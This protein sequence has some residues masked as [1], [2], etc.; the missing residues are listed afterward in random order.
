[1]AGRRRGQHGVKGRGGN[2]DTPAVR[3]RLT[4]RSS[5][6]VV[7]LLAGLTTL[8]GA[9]TRPAGAANVLSRT[10]ETPFI[11]GDW[12][13]TIAVPRF[14][15][16]LGVLQGVHL[17]L[18][19]V[20][21]GSVRAENLGAA[22]LSDVPLTAA[23]VAT[24]TLPLELSLL[25]VDG[26]LTPAAT[27]TTS[28]A[29]HD[30][31]VDYAGPSGAT[32]DDL[33]GEDRYSGDFG[34]NAFLIGFYGP[35][36]IELPVTV[37]GASVAEAA[38]VDAAFDTRVSLRASVS[39]DYAL[40]GVVLTV[41]PASASVVA[42]EPVVLTVTVRGTGELG[43]TGLFVTSGAAPD[44]ERQID[45]LAAGAEVTYECRSPATA[46][47]AAGTDAEFG[48]SVWG[49]ADG[50]MV[51]ANGAATVRLTAGVP[52]QALAV[53]VSVNGQ[54]AS[55]PPGPGFAVGTALHL[56]YQVTN[57]GPATVDDVRVTDAPVGAVTCPSG[58]L[59]PGASAAC[60]AD[61]VQTGVAPTHRTV[62][63]TARTPDGQVVS[64]A[65]G[66][67]HFARP[68]A[69]CAA[70]GLLAGVQFAIDGGPAV[71]D[72]RRLDVAPG[73]PVTMRGAGVAAG[74]PGCELYHAV[75][76]TSSALFGVGEL[77]V[78]VGSATCTIGA[79]APSEACGDPGSLSVELPGQISVG[80][81]LDAV[82]GRPLP[83]VGPSGG[84]YSAVLTGG[85][86]RLISA[87]N[88]SGS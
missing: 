13:T 77:Q 74:A 5:L 43:L 44:C 81:Q 14:D 87:R 2:A 31:A 24:F 73:N 55:L 42:G 21:R 68:S 60:T 15:P 26:V 84:Y 86:N 67:H 83:V 28:F 39:Y 47:D 71:G 16:A 36:D 17:R 20:V 88:G 30:G 72:L 34:R 63:A 11:A 58:P 61:A 56:A 6:V 66:L 41:T 38:G 48:V 64:A 85:V 22:P 76:R 25:G 9:P 78:L 52:T 40:A 51:A 29:A 4:A 32:A 69:T 50:S 70:D 62:T 27:T 7:A 1:M 75:Y 10:V 37:T 23:A 12:D 18:E 19:A 65:G 79:V 45:A 8:L 49:V 3:P 82:T 33:A 53:R 54:D 46:A 59:A 57:A 35:G 80:F